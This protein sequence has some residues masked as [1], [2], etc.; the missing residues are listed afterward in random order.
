MRMCS[1]EVVVRYTGTFALRDDLAAEYDEAALK[2]AA[3]EI[4]I[5]PPSWS[6]GTSVEK[7]E[8]SLA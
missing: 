5:D 4:A 2:E 7:V 3:V 6:S 8:V 1:Y